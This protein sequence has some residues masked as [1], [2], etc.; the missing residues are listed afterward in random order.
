MSSYHYLYRITN[1]VENKHYYGIRTSRNDILPHQDLGVKY[2]S[3]ST[4]KNF[5]KDQKEHPENYRYK[6]I[7]VSD[8][9]KKVANL[10]IKLHNKF[11][12]GVNNNFYNKVIQTSTGF[13]P[14]GKISV[15][16]KDGN[17]FYISNTDPKFLDGTLISVSTGMVSVKDSAGNFLRVSKTDGRYQNGSLVSIA[18]GMVN[19]KD[20]FGRCFSVSVDDPR[21]KSG[22]LQHH[23][24]GTVTV[25][26]KEGNRF[27][28]SVTNPLYLDGTLQHNTKGLVP[29]KDKDGN[30]SSVSVRNPLYLD[31]TLQ[32]INKGR[33]TVKDGDGNYYS[34][35]VY[36]PLY[37]NG[38]LQHISKGQVVVKNSLGKL[39]RVSNDDPRFKSGELQHHTKGQI[40]VRD[41]EGNFFNVFATDTRFISGELQHIMKG[42]RWIHNAELNKNARLKPD[43]SLPEGWKY[44]YK[45]YLNGVFKRYWKTPWGI[46]TSSAALE[47]EIIC[48]K[49]NTWC[50]TKNNNKVNKFSYYHCKKLQETFGIDCIGKTYKELGFSLLTTE[51]YQQLTI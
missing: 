51:E 31:G 3:S 14:L 2:F 10:E 45:R 20:S 8:S 50:G 42:M 36:D 18:T 4:D 27:R 15:I 26:D 5:I 49:L 9:R 40:T 34:V 33:V 12:V 25:K 19:I 11:N 23:T 1:L 41:N 21:F 30:Y 39:F 6:V 47:P 22:E 24:K 48:N 32:P 35:S 28:V 16:D 7:I 37:L 44:G 13:N 46:F 43:E 29:V 17:R 38:T